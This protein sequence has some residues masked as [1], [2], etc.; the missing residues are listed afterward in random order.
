[1]LSYGWQIIITPAY[2]PQ[3]NGIEMLWAEAK[4]IYRRAM[5]KDLLARNT[6]CIQKIAYDAIKAVSKQNCIAYA[7]KGLKCIREGE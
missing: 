1:M 3:Y 4:S 7:R 6:I 5:L 2:L